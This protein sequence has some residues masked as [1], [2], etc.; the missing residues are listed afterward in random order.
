MIRCPICNSSNSRRL[1]FRGQ[2]LL[3]R[4]QNTSCKHIFCYPQPDDERLA[5]FYGTD[6]YGD[7]NHRYCQTQRTI[8]TQI[9]RWLPEIRMPFLDVGCGEGFLYEALPTESRKHYNG[10][11]PDKAARKSARKRTGCYIAKNL[12]ALST[13]PRIYKTIV[14]NQVIEHF[15]SPLESLKIIFDISSHDAV[16]L[17]TTANSASLKARIKRAKWD[18]LQNRT[19]LHLFTKESLIVGLQ[20]TGWV[21]VEVIT[22]IIKY[23]HHAT[24]QRLVHCVLR[25][26]G[27]D[28]NLTLLAR[29]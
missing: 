18:Q 21:N 4:C 7:G 13:L 14:L 15:R 5:A 23:P 9:L 17:L 6:Y 8:F 25:K 22:S 1:H 29:K 2:V 11:E 28:G 10:V 12:E 16:L 27:L 20:K 19:H 26:T 24:L 3:Y